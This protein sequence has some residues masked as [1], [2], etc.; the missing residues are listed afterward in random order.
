MSAN[1]I[2]V[3]ALVDETRTTPVTLEVTPREFEVMID[4][5]TPW[6]VLMAVPTHAEPA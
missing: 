2:T 3:T 4:P 1:L 5:R 6:I